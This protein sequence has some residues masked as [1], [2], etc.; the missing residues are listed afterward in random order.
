MPPRGPGGFHCPPLHRPSTHIFHCI[1]G[2]F[3]LSGDRGA[4]PPQVAGMSPK[5]SVKGKGKNH[6]SLSTF[7]TGP[8]VSPSRED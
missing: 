3:R 7:G 6:R 2:P 5:N 4:E 8:Q 1:L